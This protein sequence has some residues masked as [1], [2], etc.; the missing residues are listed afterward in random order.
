MDNLFIITP[1]E[2]KENSRIEILSDDKSIR[3][4]IKLAQDFKLKP[5]L[6]DT[7]YNGLTGSI[8][9]YSVNSTSLSTDMSN[10][11]PYVKKYLI[12][13]VVSDFI[14][15]NHY[16]LT[17]KGTFKL[18]DS[19]ATSAS[20]VEMEWYRSYYDNIVSTYKRKLVKYI[21]DNVIITNTDVKDT[22]YSFRGVYM[23]IEDCSPTNER[24]DW[25]YF[26]YKK[27]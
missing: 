11:L 18:V 17:N 21:K 15:I 23:D 10:L 13:Q 14:Y 7:I 26:V 16:K 2:V 20:D 24:L 5:I 22:D 3:E 6:G 4:I 19:N 25:T 12:Y 8:Y 9:E 27:N 1:A